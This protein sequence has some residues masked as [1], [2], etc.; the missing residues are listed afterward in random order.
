V[1]SDGAT[2]GGTPAQQLSLINLL[3]AVL[4]IGLLAWAFAMNPAAALRSYLWA[5]CV[6][7]AVPCGS[8]ALLALQH[9]TGGAWGVTMRRP[10][11]AAV[12]TLPLVAL[13][14]VPLALGAHILYP[15]ANGSYTAPYPKSLYLNVPAFQLR[16]G[17]YFAVWIVLGTVLNYWSGQ[18][19][20][21]NPPDFDR[22][23]RLIAGPTIGLYGLTI[24]FASI[25]WVMSLEPMWFSSIFGVLF[26][27][28]QILSAFVF[29]ILMVLLFSDRPPLRGVIRAGHL[30]DY[31]SLLLAFVMIWM[32]LSISQF[33]LIWSANLKEEAPYYVERSHGIWPIMAGLVVLAQFFTPFLVL[34][35]RDG[36]R[37]ARSL[38]WVAGMVLA[39]R[40]AELFWFIAPARPVDHHTLFW[41][42]LVALPALAGP[43]FLFF[44]WQLSR[45]PLLPLHVDPTPAEDHHG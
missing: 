37:N 23:F 14:F 32:Y 39:A 36:K 10:L 20:R 7:A 27:V 6:V 22:R 45:R 16:A 44:T 15:W 3:F 1:A 18:Q 5:F 25:D 38:G 40:A 17:V 24:T 43:W 31:G 12:R 42:D 35:T 4:P 13:L 30:R 11:E 8:L 21:N 29:A 26:G 19:D 34:L 33:I 28:G 41:S 9:L 2:N